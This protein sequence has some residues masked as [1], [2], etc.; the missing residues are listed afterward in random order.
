[1]SPRHPGATASPR[2]VMIPKSSELESPPRVARSA[3]ARPMT[4][5]IGGGTWHL[6][7][8]AQLEIRSGLSMG[9]EIWVRQLTTRGA[10]IGV[11]NR[12]HFGCPK[13][14]KVEGIPNGI[15]PRR[16]GDRI[17]HSTCNPPGVQWRLPCPWPSKI[18]MPLGVVTIQTGSTTAKMAKA[19][20]SGDRPG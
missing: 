18:F 1:M 17:R 10:E 3:R 5:R 19:A 20:V 15:F 9:K 12:G 14:A 6:Y 8:S 11:P 4:Q 16:L 7:L 2:G 13:R